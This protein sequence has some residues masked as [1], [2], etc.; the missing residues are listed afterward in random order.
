MTAPF[1][2]ENFDVVEN[3][4]G[5]MDSRLETFMENQFCFESREETFCDCVV[6][7]VAASAHALQA[8]VLL[9]LASEQVTGILATAIR[10]RDDGSMS[11]PLYTH[12]E[13]V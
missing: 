11:P 3:C 4:R 2:V 8:I 12:L 10:V 9:Q 13:G 5:C 1:V 7:T 6:P